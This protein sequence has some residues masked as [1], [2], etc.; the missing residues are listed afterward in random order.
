MGEMVIFDDGTA[1]ILGGQL[2]EPQDIVIYCDLCNEPVAITPEA[3]DK[4]FITCLKCHAVSHIKVQT[5]KE[6]DDESQAQ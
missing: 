6:P 3:N 5:N 2:E 4:V 1:T